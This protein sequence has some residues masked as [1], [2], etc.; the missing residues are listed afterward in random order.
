[1]IKQFQNTS[2]YNYRNVLVQYKIYYRLRQ[3]FD[4]WVLHKYM[5]LRGDLSY[6]KNTK[7]YWLIHGMYY[8]HF[9]LKTF[10]CE[11]RILELKMLFEFSEHNVWFLSSQSF[12]KNWLHR[13]FT[14]SKLHVKTLS[15]PSQFFSNSSSCLSYSETRTFYKFW[16]HFLTFNL[17]NC[18]VQYT[19]RHVKFWLE[20]VYHSRYSMTVQGSNS[21]RVRDF[22]FSETIQ[23]SSGAHPVSYAMGT[24]VSPQG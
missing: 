9:P 8:T 13:T 4:Y 24:G 22:L 18:G 2:A 19:W 14:H 7:H 10:M 1:M 23:T 6:T 21:H 12:Q 20:S 11:M 3:Y 17:I 16:Q 15:R 5:F